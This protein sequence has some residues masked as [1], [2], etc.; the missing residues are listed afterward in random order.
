MEGSSNC[1]NHA[2]FPVLTEVPDE[3][4]EQH[5]IIAS[6]L[7]IFEQALLKYVTVV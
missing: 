3:I 7:R 5:V 4:V 6:M 1:L 2:I